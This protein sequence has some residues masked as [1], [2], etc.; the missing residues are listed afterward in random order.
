MPRLA[1]EGVVGADAIFAS[2]GPALEVFSRH[3]RVE[4]A[5]GEVAKL[6][7][8]L[9]HVWA[10]VA[11]EALSMIF[12]D[13][14]AAGLE[15]DARLTTMWL[16]TIG[17]GTRPGNGNGE[18]EENE[19]PDEEGEEA[20]AG[21]SGGFALEFDAAR[22]IAQGLGVI[23]EKCESIVAVKGDTA[24][25]LPVAER[26]RRLF[27]K[28]SDTEASGGKKGKKKPQQQSLFEALGDAKEAEGARVELQ[29][30][31]PGSTVLDRLHQAMIL[32]GAGRGELLKRFLLENSVGKDARLWKLAQSLS[33][34]YPAGSDEKRWVDGVLARKKGLG[35]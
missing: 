29:G 19:P 15:P 1:Q 6:R 7:E 20:K 27:G 28:D 23:L 21:S 22:M 34:L 31:S 5:S 25:L 11:T 12:K 30:P 2:L 17:S 16:W 26:T 9:E 13:A 24:R 8:Y 33:A 35:L 3:S 18:A 32:F 4:K 14:D 10:A